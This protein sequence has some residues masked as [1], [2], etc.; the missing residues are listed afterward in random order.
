MFKNHKNQEVKKK[1]LRNQDIFPIKTVL[2]LFPLDE[3][4]CLGT[5]MAFPESTKEQNLSVDSSS[6]QASSPQVL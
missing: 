3:S 6:G 1:N 4:K 2:V 5:Q